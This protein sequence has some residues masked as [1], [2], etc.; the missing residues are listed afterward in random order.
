[1]DWG[2]PDSR[3]TNRHL[4]GNSLNSGEFDI[5]SLGEDSSEVWRAIL[6]GRLG[7]R[8]RE[9]GEGQARAR[10]FGF[11]EPNPR[12]YGGFPK[13]LLRALPTFANNAMIA[14]REALGMAFPDG[15][16]AVGPETLFTGGVFCKESRGPP[17][18]FAAFR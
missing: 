18:V 11:L 7:Y 9:I 10:F 16:T 2:R 8:Y 14:A 4:E 3:V 15:Q 12:R 17:W 1:M 6:A 13:S 5:S